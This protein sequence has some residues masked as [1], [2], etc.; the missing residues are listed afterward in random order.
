MS[1]SNSGQAFFAGIL[2]ALDTVKNTSRIDVYGFNWSDRSYAQHQMS[3]EE[4]IVQALKEAHP[5]LQIHPTPCNGLYHCNQI[6]DTAQFRL[7][8]DEENCNRQ[9]RNWLSCLVHS[10]HQD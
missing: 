8:V 7:A 10:I 5:R 9:V 1:C 2:A 3:N 6:C 4:L